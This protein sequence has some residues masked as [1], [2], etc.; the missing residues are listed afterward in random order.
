MSKSLLFISLPLSDEAK[1][2]ASFLVIKVLLCANCTSPRGN[3]VFQYLKPRS[4][5][6]EGRFQH[7]LG[8]DWTGT[9]GAVCA[10]LKLRSLHFTHSVYV[11]SRYFH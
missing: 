3:G 9:D 10:A 8:A 1:V 4:R 7:K 5:P 2:L 6:T 11:A